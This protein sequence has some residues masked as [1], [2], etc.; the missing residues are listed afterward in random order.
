MPDPE[1]AL[2][3]HAFCL[4]SFERFFNRAVLQANRPSDISE[5]RHVVSDIEEVRMSN[6]KSIAAL[7]AACLC[8]AADTAADWKADVA[9]KV[10]GRVVREGLEEAM[11]DAALDAALDAAARGAAEYT[12][13]ELRDIDKLDTIGATVGE[14]IETAMRVADVADTLDDIADVAKTVKTINKVRKV[15]R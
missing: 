1:I 11:K 5:S 2:A 13:S 8:F 14:G 4:A 12:A 10:V 15:I 7:A 3:R 6:M 9:G